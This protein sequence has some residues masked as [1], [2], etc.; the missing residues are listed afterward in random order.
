MGRQ[1]VVSLVMRA[2]PSIYRT[3]MTSHEKNIFMIQVCSDL[4]NLHLLA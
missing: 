1:R 3:L 2:W 4:G